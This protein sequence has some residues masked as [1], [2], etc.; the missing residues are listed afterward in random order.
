MKTAE[1]KGEHAI[2]ETLKSPEFAASLLP[3]SSPR[4]LV[5]DLAENTTVKQLAERLDA[6]ALRAMRQ[7][8]ACLVEKYF[9]PKQ[10]FK[11][12]V[13][14]MAIAVALRDNHDAL[15]SEYLRELSELAD[16]AEF[17]RPAC[18]AREIVRQRER[19]EAPDEG[20]DDSK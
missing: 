5:R 1:P 16:T 8:V 10:Q 17:H 12:D 4:L 15:A 2:V 19:K 11:F 9:V 13:F 7:T 3:T 6:Y 18:V 14:L 20:Q